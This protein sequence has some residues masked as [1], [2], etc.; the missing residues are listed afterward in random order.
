[1][2]IGLGLVASLLLSACQ[3][4]K[5][6]GEL[7]ELQQRQEQ[8]DLKLQQLEQRVINLA[9]ATRP[10]ALAN[11]SRSGEVAHLPQRQRRRPA[12]DLLGRWHQQRP[13]LHE[14]AIHI[15]LRLTAA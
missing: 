14:G 11:P 7:K 1:M 12:A 9:P 4:P 2:L 8:L 5:P 13:A 10:T 15:G 3:Q 6:T